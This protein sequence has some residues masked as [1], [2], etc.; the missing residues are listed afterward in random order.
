[1]DYKKYAIKQFFNEI[2]K[3]SHSV[4]MLREAIEGGGYPLSG[5]LN[6]ILANGCTRL[7][8]RMLTDDPHTSHEFRLNE[9]GLKLYWRTNLENNSLKVRIGGDQERSYPK[10]VAAVRRIIECNDCLR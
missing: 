2:I 7:I 8:D 10:F 6:A 3:L 9:A 5:L 4:F 1:M